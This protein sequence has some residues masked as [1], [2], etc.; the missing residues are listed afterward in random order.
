MKERIPVYLESP[1]S[2]DEKKNIAYARACMLDSLN[3][4]EAP[5]ASHLLYTQVWDDSNPEERT[6]GIEA[7]FAI[8]K[9]CKKT[10]LY[11]DFGTSYGM[12]LGIENARFH[13]RKVETRYLP[14]KDIKRFWLIR[15]DVNGLL[16]ELCLCL[17]ITV[18]QLRGRCRNVNFVFARHAFIR[19]AKEQFPHLTTYKLGNL[20][21]KNHSTV[22]FYMKELDSINGVKEKREFCQDLKRKLNL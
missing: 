7:G 11:C 5:F 1:Y 8:A 17:K 12:Q 18:E 16:H 19:I 21:N 2:G 20:I 22:T 15:T 6:A 13:K 14:E 9:L 10:V 3:L 4:G